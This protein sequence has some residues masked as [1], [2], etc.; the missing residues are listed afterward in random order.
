MFTHCFGWPTV[1]H[2]SLEKGPESDLVRF[3]WKKAYMKYQYHTHASHETRY[4]EDLA[5]KTSEF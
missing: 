5:I 4:M 3:P 2:K 1:E